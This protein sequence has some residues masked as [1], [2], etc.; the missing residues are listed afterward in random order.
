M[1]SLAVLIPVKSSGA[2]SRLSKILSQSERREFVALLLSG[3]LAELSKAR[4]LRATY[5]ISS[6]EET[7]SR[8]SREGATPI[9]EAGDEGV[10]SAV[11][12]GIESVNGATS[13]L[14]LPSDLPLATSSQIRHLLALGWSTGR[15]VIVPSLTF[16]GTNALFFAPSSGL[17]LSYDDDSFW[18][19]L[20][21]AGREG[22]RC[23]ISTMTGLMF[24]VDSPAD[25]ENLARVRSERPSVRFA[26]RMCQW[27]GY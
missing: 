6:D 17:E 26:R 10:N 11:T 1:S 3:L 16:N 25:L 5:V 8:A 15:A 18:N 21:S 24:D 27:P 20:E 2:K 9:R 14:V 19:H 7:L 4:L 23:A 13:Y 12:L 22:L